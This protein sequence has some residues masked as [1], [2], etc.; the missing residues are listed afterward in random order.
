PKNPSYAA[1]KYYPDGKEAWAS[2]VV[3]RL[4]NWG[5]NTIGAWSDAKDLMKVK[6]PGLRFT[7]ILHMGSGA[8]APW[9]DMWEPKTVD[10]M[11]AIARD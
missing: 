7:P 1:F 3:D 6:A 4:Q 9:V 2:D 5:F 11:N 10:L 8:G